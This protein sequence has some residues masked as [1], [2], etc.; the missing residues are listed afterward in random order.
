[1]GF[2]RVPDA[3]GRERRWGLR[4]QSPTARGRPPVTGAARAVRCCQTWHSRRTFFF[5]IAF[6]S[7][8]SAWHPHCFRTSRRP[9]SCTRRG[10]AS[11]TQI[12][13]ASTPTAYPSTNPPDSEVSGLQLTLGVT[14]MRRGQIQ[15]A[16]AT[17]ARVI[18]GGEGDVNKVRRKPEASSSKSRAYGSSRT[19]TS[20]KYDHSANWKAGM[21]CVRRRVGRLRVPTSAER[22]RFNATS[23]VWAEGIFSDFFETIFGAPAEWGM[24]SRAA[25]G[26]AH[27]AALAT[28]ARRGEDSRSQSASRSL[29]LSSGTR[30]IQRE[31]SVPDDPSSR[32]SKTT[33]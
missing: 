17:G 1:V 28:R 6:R 30:P 21:S 33:R 32:L 25:R 10:I 16:F 14:A 4:T 8:V 5:E 20:E 29:K 7:H 22:A 9:W 12:T 13:I 18:T 31:T 2:N 26:G 24:C 3:A 23:A 19:L 27:Q 11:M 15:R